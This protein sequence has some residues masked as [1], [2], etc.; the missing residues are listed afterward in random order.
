MIVTDEPFA[1]TGIVV[2]EVLEG[3]VRNV[4]EVARYLSLCDMIEARGLSTY[5][6]AASIFRQ[7]R[8]RGVSIATIDALR[9]AIALEHGATVF[10]LDNDFSRIARFTPL[11]LYTFG[12]RQGA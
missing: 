5:E 9:A 1:L 11:R 3:L 6:E 10:T 12:G 2:T 7:G 4:V 8:S